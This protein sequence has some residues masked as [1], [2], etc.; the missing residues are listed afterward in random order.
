[1]PGPKA[2]G[3]GSSNVPETSDTMDSPSSPN[4][5]LELSGEIP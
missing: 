5:I 2:P 1:M 3:L 4:K